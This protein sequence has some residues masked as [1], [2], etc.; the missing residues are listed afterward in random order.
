MTIEPLQQQQN[1][2]GAKPPGSVQFEI[3]KDVLRQAIGASSN[4][5]QNQL[6]QLIS[7]IPNLQQ[8]QSTAQ[9]QIAKG[10]LDIKI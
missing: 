3:Q 5:L 9:N 1:N 4:S 8:A 2:D 10:F 6:L 7:N